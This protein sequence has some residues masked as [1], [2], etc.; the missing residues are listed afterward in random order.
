MAEGRG[1]TIGARV[2]LDP[3]I[4]E[5]ADR[6]TL[7]LFVGAGV[8]RLVGCEGWD[9][10]ALDLLKICYDK[11]F[12][13]Y[14]ASRELKS[15][16]D[17]RQLITICYHLLKDRGQEKLFYRK[18]RA[19]LKPDKNR[20]AL[21]DGL[22]ER[23]SRMQQFCIVTT[24]ADKNLDQHFN[25]N[26]VSKA[27]EFPSEP[28]PGFLYHLHG[29]IDDIRNVVF[30]LERYFD[31]Y[32]EN[33]GSPHNGIP[34]FL[35]YLFGHYNILFLGY[36]LSE[37]E[38][39]EFIFKRPET[40]SRSLYQ[41]FMLIDDS[42]DRF[43]TS[44]L[45]GYYDEMHVKLIPYNTD[46][47]GHNELY[48]VIKDWSQQL[49]PAQRYSNLPDEQGRLRIYAIQT[50]DPKTTEGV[51]NL[52]QRSSLE[53][54]FFNTLSDSN[55]DIRQSWLVP[56]D[57]HVCFS[58][59]G[60][61]SL[62]QEESSGPVEEVF[63]SPIGYLHNVIESAVKSQRTDVLDTIAHI[64]VEL[65]RALVEKPL[66][67]YDWRTNWFILQALVVSKKTLSKPMMHEIALRLMTVESSNL[68]LRMTISDELVKL[69]V[70]QGN[71]AALKMILK[72]FLDRMGR[73]PKGAQDNLTSRFEKAI[74]PHAGKL[75]GC[76]G[77]TVVLMCADTLRDWQRAL[78]SGSTYYEVPSVEES[79]QN[80]DKEHSA[81]LAIVRFIRSGYDQMLPGQRRTVTKQLL[82]SR[83]S[84]LRR[85]G[86]YLV[87]AHYDSMSSMFWQIRRNP[88][89]DEDAFHEVFM[90]LRAHASELNGK[91]I[92][93]ILEWLNAAELARGHE[94][95]PDKVARLAMGKRFKAKWLLSLKNS[96]DTRIQ[97]LVTET[98]SDRPQPTHPEWSFYIGEVERDD[99]G[100]VTAATLQGF[101][102]NAELAA[103]LKAT[104]IS[105]VYGA[106]QEMV[107]NDPDRLVARG[108]NDMLGVPVSFLQAVFIGFMLAV[109]NKRTFQVASV[110]QLGE[111]TLARLLGSPERDPT[112]ENRRG[113]CRSICEFV[114]TAVRNQSISWVRDDKLVQDLVQEALELGTKY[115]VTDPGLMEPRW[116]LGNSALAAA[117]QA[118]I[119]AAWGLRK[120]TRKGSQSSS[121]LPEWA[122]KLLDSALCY[123]NPTLQIEAR[124]GIA[125]NLYVL[126]IVD[127]NWVNGNLDLIFPKEFPDQW[128]DAFSAYLTAP[129]NQELFLLLSDRGVYSNA[130]EH[131]FLGE[132]EDESLAAHVSLAY[133][134]GLDGGLMDTM[135]A[136]A[137]AG[138]LSEVIWYFAN[139]ERKWTGEGRERLLVLWP[140]MIEAIRQLSDQ[141]EQK[142]QL[143]ELP[144]WLRAFE[145]LPAY[146]E[147][148]LETS[149]GRWEKDSSEFDLLESLAL[150]AENDPERVGNILLS[151]AENGILLLFPEEE[152]KKIAETLCEKGFF[153][154]VRKIHSKYSSKGAYVLLPVLEKWKKEHGSGLT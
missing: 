141:D 131:D 123:T 129:V 67:K 78:K 122:A 12:I 115:P 112:K 76:C 38:I 144:T 22:F 62:K 89:L 13:N 99:S 17:H 20:M 85:I 110:L 6:G 27:G 64:G 35:R 63:W 106:L 92:G 132:S 149:F 101:E 24:N 91:Q 88:L 50:Y 19:A 75:V 8:S 118:T 107:S 124:E 9:D 34:E 127:P 29:S 53:T 126:N 140:K 148:W 10:L 54:F 94:V 68:S 120:T 21:M 147:D 145:R 143:S 74:L 113:V 130:I 116:R 55:S 137:S 56:L 40:A 117:V 49:E 108:L 44:Y 146:A 109:Q 46:V 80:R 136:H 57:E 105:S 83:D 60:H 86:Y 59:K 95:G 2:P 41:H 23:L 71:R 30:T 87:N 81:P 3:Q 142:K 14:R 58:P 43:R 1:S 4:I 134:S 79:D 5:A 154:M 42:A 25:K 103:F 37:F 151:A 121:H 31:Q 28:R 73:Q 125:A 150:F 47:S 45:Q 69:L 97:N 93:V 90:L 102:T 52:L 48:Q 98:W 96:T 36:G 51:W 18:L 84:L 114:S 70:E 100:I 39:L 152:L 133:I 153:D 11:G 65:A 26:I 111:S 32:S 135:L 61:P 139:R 138:R 16:G 104:N 128:R 7:V 82:V 77:S 15:L 66:K 119:W 72:V 33:Q